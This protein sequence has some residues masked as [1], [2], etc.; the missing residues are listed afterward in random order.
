M[1]ENMKISSE[2]F[3]IYIKELVPR[4]MRFPPGQWIRIDTL[5][6]DVNRFI[7]ICQN[8]YDR[9]YFEDDDGFLVLEIKEDTF[10][11]LDPMYI[12]RHSKSFQLWK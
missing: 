7:A 8:L 12:R 10:V 3:D 5:A 11:R 4:L 1:N 9:G 6:K 2:E